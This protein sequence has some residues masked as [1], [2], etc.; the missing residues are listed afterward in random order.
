VRES[1]DETVDEAQI[2]TE[3]DDIVVFVGDKAA[4]ATSSE[5]GGGSRRGS[6]GRRS[7]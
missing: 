2:T 5:P 6:D 1:P 7:A 3:F 4:I